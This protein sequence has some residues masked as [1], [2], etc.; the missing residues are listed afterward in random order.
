MWIEFSEFNIKLLLPLIFP[1]FKRVQDY[2]KKTYLTKDNQLFKTFRYFMSYMFS[3]IPFLIMK[4]RTKNTKEIEKSTELNKEN[5]NEKGIIETRALSVVKG[6]IE[7]RTISFVNYGLTNE[8]TE[9]KKKNDKKR[10]IYNIIFLFILCIMGLFCYLF[11]WLFELEEFSEPKQSIGIFFEIFDYALLSYFILKQKLY[12]HHFV[13]AGIIAVL[14]IILFIITIPYRKNNKFFLSIVYFFFYSLCFGSYDI[15]GKKYMIKYFVT[16]YF[17]M[18]IVGFIDVIFLL[19]YELFSYFLNP[20][21]SGITFGF[22]NNINKV[23]DVFLFILDLIVEDIWNLGIWLTVY[24]LTPCH[25]FISEYI[26]EY[27]YYMI[28]ARQKKDTNKFYSTTN[29]VIFSICYFIN[30]LCCLIFNEVFILNFC[31]LDYNTRKRI[32]QR[33]SKEKTDLIDSQ[34]LIE[35]GTEKDEDESN[36]VNID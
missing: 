27:V 5:V 8:I 20:S 10:T 33:I 24:Y 34:N 30:F 14:L 12:K 29:V 1:I 11:R 23:G 4:I 19:I 25:Y 3:I 28:E 35:M 18:F 32:N 9:L 6:I 16:P 36:E 7:T 2:T 26:S 31:G 22:R 13:S 17:F 15:L 21:I